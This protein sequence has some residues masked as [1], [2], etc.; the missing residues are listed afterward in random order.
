[1]KLFRKLVSTE[2]SNKVL[3]DILSAPHHSQYRLFLDESDQL[4]P[5]KTAS[6]DSANSESEKSARLLFLVILIVI[7]AAIQAQKQTPTSRRISLPPGA[8]LNYLADF[9]CSPKTMERVVSPVISDMQ[10]EYCE[11]LAQGRQV[12]A[13]WIRVRGYWSFWKGLGLYAAVK[14]LTEIWKISRLG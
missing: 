14:N 12:K 4:G 1:L 2:P 8:L 5:L 10:K 3:L 13:R 6:N 9:F 7:W 11:A